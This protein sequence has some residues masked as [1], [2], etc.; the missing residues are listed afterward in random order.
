MER[1][2]QFVDSELLAHAMLG[3]KRASVLMS[4]AYKF[5]MAQVSSP[6]RQESFYL[7]FRRPGWYYIPFDINELVRCLLPVAS[8]KQ[9]DLILSSFG[10]S[11]SV[12]MRQALQSEVSVNAAPA[13]SWVCAREPIVSITGPSFLVSWL[14]AMCIW[15]N[16]PIQVATE[17]L[18]GKDEFVVSCE[19]EATIVRLVL[20]SLPPR[21]NVRVR[22]G[23]QEFSDAVLCNALDLQ[24]ALSS[25]SNDE[26]SRVFE[27]GMRGATCM[28]M[29]R[30]AL[31]S[32]KRAGIFKTS[33]VALAHELGMSAVGSTGHEHQMRFG[34]D[35]SGFRAIRDGRTGVPSYL[36]DTYDAIELGIPAAIDVWRESPDIGASVRFD[37]G[38]TEMQ[39]RMF[40]EAGVQPHFIFMDGMNATRIEELEAL[41][42][43]LGIPEERRSYGVGGFLGC[44]LLTHSLSRNRVSAVYKLSQSGEEPVMKFSKEGKQSLPGKVQVMR[45]IRGDGPVSIIAQVGEEVDN[46]YT[47]LKNWSVGPL[48]TMP[49]GPAPIASSLTQKKID[50][51]RSRY[52]THTQ[53]NTNQKGIEHEH[54]IT[55]H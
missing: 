18:A 10:L 49:L 21:P 22:I 33:N 26:S 54:T 34:E 27:V 31:A 15:M 9:D 11:M 16:F 41:C 51:L 7:S 23:E 37:S 38:D 14:E 3:Q 20:D 12:A 24:A 55:N 13:G 36:F 40:V 45:K 1:K 17:A 32:V 39:L 25:N 4:D 19:D 30:L 43:E 48:A 35:R 2:R 42:N 50:V 46:D 47:L 28:S 5:S 52:F 44:S 6:L 53:N 29:H 8:T